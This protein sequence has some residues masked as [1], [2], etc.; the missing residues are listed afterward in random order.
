[1]PRM[2][3]STDRTQRGGFA[4]AIAA[5]QRDDLAFLDCERD[6]LQ[7]LDLVVEDMDVVDFQQRH[8]G[9]SAAGF[10]AEPR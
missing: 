2:Q 6:A 10:A 5:D 7:G 8:P 3:Q 9:Y 1:M 4:G